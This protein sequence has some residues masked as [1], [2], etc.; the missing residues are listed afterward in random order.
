MDLI[1]PGVDGNDV[2]L[3]FSTLV[4]LEKA[5]LDH[6]RRPIASKYATPNS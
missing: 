6:D 2:L 5:Y 1:S 3:N 4:Y